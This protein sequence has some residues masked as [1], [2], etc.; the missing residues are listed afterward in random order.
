MEEWAGTQELTAR[1]WVLYN[2]RA[3]E[4]VWEFLGEHGVQT[5]KPWRE[6]FLTILRRTD[7]ALGEPIYWPPEAKS[8]IAGRKLMPGKM[9]CR[10]RERHRARWLQSITDSRVLGL[11][12]TLGYLKG[13]CYTWSYKSL[14]SLS[15]WA[16]SK[17]RTGMLGR[18][19]RL[20]VKSVT[21]IRMVSENRD[22]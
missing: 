4:D 16:K 11:N 5:C 15:D 21:G 1:I 22:N 17:I 2:S 8:K 12:K 9:G 20:H 10:R 18:W 19:F 13:R 7:A 6:A 14:T 3:R